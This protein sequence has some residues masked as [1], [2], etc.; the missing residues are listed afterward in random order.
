MKRELQ[1]HTKSCKGCGYC[2]HSCP[3]KALSLTGQMNAKGYITV[4]VDR[5]RCILCGI[6]YTVCPD[7][8]YEI[9][10]VSGGHETINERQ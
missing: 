7:Y 4:E 5:S 2:V 9:K 10:E 6:C 3:K 8:V 1:L